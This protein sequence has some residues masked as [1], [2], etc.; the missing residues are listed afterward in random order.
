IASFAA[1]SELFVLQTYPTLLSAVVMYDT[2]SSRI[3]K[4]VFKHA[5]LIPCFIA[6]KLFVILCIIFGGIML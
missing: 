2:C 6:N 5:F 3:C 4:Y 1:V